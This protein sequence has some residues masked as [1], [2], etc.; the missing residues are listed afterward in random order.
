MPG[1]IR[2]AFVRLFLED[3]RFH[4][5]SLGRRERPVR[6][7]QGR[8]NASRSY[9]AWF[10]AWVIRFQGRHLG[11]CRKDA[12][13]RRLHEQPAGHMVTMVFSCVA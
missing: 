9:F 10:K 11:C 13:L 12:E 4:L 1:K 6:W 3:M 2:H 7:G 5:A 8:Y